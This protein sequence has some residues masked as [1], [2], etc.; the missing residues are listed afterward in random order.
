MRRFYYLAFMGFIIAACSSV[1]SG[2]E[3]VVES[4]ADESK[5]VAGWEYTTQI[6]LSSQEKDIDRV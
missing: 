5:D 6:S 2:A 4:P 3:P 1:D